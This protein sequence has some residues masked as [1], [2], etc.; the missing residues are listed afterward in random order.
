MFILCV[1]GSGGLWVSRSERGSVLLGGNH[2]RKP[3]THGTVLSDCQA[4]LLY[5]ICFLIQF[6]ISGKLNYLCIYSF[7]IYLYVVALCVLT[8]S[9]WTFR[10]HLFFSYVP[11]DL[12]TKW[13]GKCYSRCIRDSC[14]WLGLFTPVVNRHRNHFGSVKD[15]CITVAWFHGKHYARVDRAHEGWLTSISNWNFNQIVIFI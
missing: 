1:F 14:V 15:T 11:V 13:S 8:L 10:S 3:P 4:T 12:M 6:I 5:C 9:S 2:S 7:V